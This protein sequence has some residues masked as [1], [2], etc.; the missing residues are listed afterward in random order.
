MRNTEVRF[1]QIETG[2]Y[3]WMTKA[4]DVPVFVKGYLGQHNGQHYVRIKGSKTGIPWN[5]LRRPA[6]ELAKA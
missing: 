4:G 3:I 2:R 1:L 6:K 5:E